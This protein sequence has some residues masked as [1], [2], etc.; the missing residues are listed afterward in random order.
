MQ[1]RAVAFDT[2]EEVVPREETMNAES[3]VIASYPITAVK[4]AEIHKDLL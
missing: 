4:E 2:L 3:L 1:R